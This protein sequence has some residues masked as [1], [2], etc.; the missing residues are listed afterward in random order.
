MDSLLT[1]VGDVEH[2]EHECANLSN[3]ADFHVLTK[4][5]ERGIDEYIATDIIFTNMVAQKEYKTCIVTAFDKEKTVLIWI[6]C[7]C[8]WMT[9]VKEDLQLWLKGIDPAGWETH[10]LKTR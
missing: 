10:V 8:S 6:A 3:C 4:K 7:V 1:V 5:M 9:C 2:E